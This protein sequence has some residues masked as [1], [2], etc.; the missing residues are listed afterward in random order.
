M[1]F[2]L[3]M[4]VRASAEESVVCVFN[5]PGRRGGYEINIRD[6]SSLAIKSL[7]SASVPNFVLQLHH[8][9][10]GDQGQ[11]CL[12]LDTIAAQYLET[13]RQW[14][15]Y[16]LTLARSVGLWTE[17][18]PKIVILPVCWHAHYFTLVAILEEQPQLVILE[19]FGGYAEPPVAKYFRDFLLHLKGT[20]GTVFQTTTPEVPRQEE[21]SNDCSLFLITICKNI[22]DDPVDFKQRLSSGNLTNWFPPHQVRPMRRELVNQFRSLGEQQRQP[23]GVLEGQDIDWP[24]V[25]LGQVRSL[26]N[27]L[28]G[29][30]FFHKKSTF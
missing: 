23:G 13:G 27:K 7:V 12:V 26:K 3:C 9:S 10:L 2:N 20:P 15:R 24:H 5:P 1:F 19:S 6:F 28:F 18:G 29:Y 8:S 22:M 21:S 4:Q 17:S 14:P 16:L 30:L 11:E 25:Y